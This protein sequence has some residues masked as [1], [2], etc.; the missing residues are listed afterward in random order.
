MDTAIYYGVRSESIPVT[1]ERGPRAP[2]QSPLPAQRRKRSPKGRRQPNPPRPRS[3][4]AHPRGRGRPRSYRLQTLAGARRG[5]GESD[6]E[7]VG[8]GCGGAGD[9]LLGFDED[10]RTT[11]GAEVRSRGVIFS[12][13]SRLGLFCLKP[14]GVRVERT[15]MIGSLLPCALSATSAGKSTT[16]AR[17]PCELTKP[18][19]EPTERMG[20]YLLA[21][22]TANQ[23]NHESPELRRLFRRLRRAALARRNRMRQLS[24]SRRWARSRRGRCPR[25]DQRELVPS[26]DVPAAGIAAGR[27][28]SWMS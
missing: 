4:Q 16:R 14:A 9:G 15:G 27:A 17:G 23:N 22:Q 20:R 26:R 2:N 7:N 12:A 25:Q 19:S 1:R 24:P 28:S 13:L 10:A 18:A 3:C 11:A 21:P 8:A 5:A 6:R